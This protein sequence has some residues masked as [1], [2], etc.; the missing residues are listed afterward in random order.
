M[1]TP[2]LP[3]PTKLWH[4]DTYLTISPSRPELS[5]AGK[6]VIVTGA[7]S[8]IGRATALSFANAGAA[9]VIL[10]GRTES[11]L[12]ETSAL[13]P[14]SCQ[15]IVHATSVTD[16]E[17]IKTIASTVGSWDVLILNAAFASPKATIADSD[18]DGWWQNFETNVKGLLIPVKAFLATAN[19]K[20]AVLGVTSGFFAMP[21]QWLVGLSAYQGSKIAQV[22]AL[23]IFAAENP[24]LFVASV[25]PGMLVTDVFSASGAKP[26]ELPMDTFDLPGDFMVW[27][28]SAEG[29]F[30]NG[31]CLWANWDVEEL[32]SRKDEIVA[33]P[34]FLTTGILGWPFA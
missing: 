7:G 11:T 26:E 31:K 21:S 6:T 24:N 13:L 1:T 34:F 20:A 10:I 25:H 32:K 18:I 16:A 9:K 2:P 8:G 29:R 30:L 22:K 28:S 3:C 14:K 19:E 15:G 33:N 12:K 27:L 4:N 23:E 5:C 17:K